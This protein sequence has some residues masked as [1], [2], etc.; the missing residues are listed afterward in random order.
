MSYKV[1]S[2]CGE[3]KKLQAKVKHRS[4]YIRAANKTEFSKSIRKSLEIQNIS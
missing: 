2:L 4:I 3:Q 1:H